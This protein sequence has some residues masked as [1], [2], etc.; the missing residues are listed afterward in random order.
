MSRESDFEMIVKE[1]DN[2]RQAIRTLEY[3][4]VAIA[5]N[6]FLSP[7]L[8]YDMSGEE[9]EKVNMA[10]K[11]IRRYVYGTLDSEALEKTLFHARWA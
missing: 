11:V 8:S 2:I 4:A 9:E 10:H 7:L 6:N 1:L 5:D 3:A